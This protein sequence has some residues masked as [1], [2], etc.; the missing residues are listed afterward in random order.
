MTVLFGLVALA[1]LLWMAQK[2]LK[3]DPRKLA[4]AAKLAGGLGLLGL[5]AV[6]GLRGH[7]EMAVPLAGSGAGAAR[8]D[9]VRAAGSGRARRKAQDRSPRVRS[10]FLEMELDHD[11]GSMR[12]M[13]LTGARTARGSSAR[14]RYAGRPARRVR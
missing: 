13:I 9:T 7:F 12:G 8:R 6:L 5:A 10:A 1:L 3:A 14:P 4:A 11:T 2:Y